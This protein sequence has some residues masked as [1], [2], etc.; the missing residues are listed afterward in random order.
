[1]L[2]K[3]QHIQMADQDKNKLTVAQVGLMALQERYPCK[4]NHVPQITIQ[5]RGNSPAQKMLH[6]GKMAALM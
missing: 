1:M 6:I 5:H 3:Y 2:E 4:A